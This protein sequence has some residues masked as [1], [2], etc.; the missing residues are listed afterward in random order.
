[1]GLV[2][3]SYIDYQAGYAGRANDMWS[4]GVAICD[5]V[6]DGLYDFRWISIN[7]LRREYG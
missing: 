2:V 7:Q 1:M 6:E 3:G 5:N 4:R